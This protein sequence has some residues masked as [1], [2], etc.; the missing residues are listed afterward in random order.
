MSDLRKIVLEHDTLIA[1]QRSVQSAEACWGQTRWHPRIP[2]A[3]AYAVA[4]ERGSLPFDDVHGGRVVAF[5]EG[6]IFAARAEYDPKIPELLAYIIDN[7]GSSY[8]GELC[9]KLERLASEILG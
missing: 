9:E 6:M 3:D 8:S 7:K 4:Q 5:L 2:W 1:G